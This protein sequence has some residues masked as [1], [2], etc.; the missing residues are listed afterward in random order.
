[1]L[2]LNNIADLIKEL[3]MS[4]V[5]DILLTHKEKQSSIN[6]FNKKLN[7]INYDSLIELDFTKIPHGGGK[8]FQSNILC[9]AYNYCDIDKI[10]DILNDHEWERPNFVQL[11][12][13]HEDYDDFISVKPN[14][15]LNLLSK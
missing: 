10:I 8:V 9:A 3:N 12:Y 6:A 13:R 14:K 2:S 15:Y 1:M 5:T 11:M 7:D 4:V